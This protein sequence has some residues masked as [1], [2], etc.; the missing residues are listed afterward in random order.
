MSARRVVGILAI[1][2]SI[3]LSACT[4][5]TGTGGSSPRPSATTDPSPTSSLIPTHGTDSF[6]FG[7]FVTFRTNKGFSP[8][9]LVVP[10]DTPIV[11]RNQATS[12]VTVR[13]DNYGSPVTSGPIAPGSTWS[14]NPHSGVSIAYHA[15]YAG[16]RYKAFI[17][18]QLAGN[19]GA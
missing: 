5:S 3:T 6:G 16:H 13:F 8:E 17:Q 14:F 12:P 2:G 7:N 18:A 9:T 19:S 1:A 4:S 15:I 11:W 10:F